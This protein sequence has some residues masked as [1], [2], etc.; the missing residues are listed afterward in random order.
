[1]GGKGILE[2]FGQVVRQA[3]LAQRLSQEQLALDAGLNRNFVMSIEA[4]RRKPSL[5]TI[6]ALAKALHLS[7]AVLVS[8]TDRN[9][10]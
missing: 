5:I 9:S 8:R 3:R 1:M 10:R 4:G 2:A 7:P 6:F